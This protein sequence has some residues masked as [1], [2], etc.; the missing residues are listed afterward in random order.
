MPSAKKLTALAALLIILALAALPAPAMVKP[1]VQAA[2]ITLP[3][4]QGVDHR[5]YDLI[6]G[7]VAVLV[8][9]SL[10]CPHCQREMPRLTRLAK[11]FTGNPFIMLTVNADGV[12]MSQAIAVYAKQQRVPG[13]YLIDSGPNDTVPFADGF[14]LF[15][16][17]S[18]IVL[19]RQGKVILAVEMEVDPKA[20]AAAVESAF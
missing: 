11:R 3:D 10:S 8:Y 7:K 2:D 5:L 17:P 4:D 14:D 6:K 12:E 1:G 13:P 16:T 19:D 15:T 9:W 20:L 18:I